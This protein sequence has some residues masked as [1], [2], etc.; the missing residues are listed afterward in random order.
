MAKSPLNTYS[1]VM[2]FVK[3]GDPDKSAVLQR[4][5][6]GHGKKEKEETIRLIEKWIVNGALGPK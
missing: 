1:S 4:I 6:A 5:K 2:S 3:P